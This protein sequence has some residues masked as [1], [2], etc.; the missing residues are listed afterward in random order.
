M[1]SPKCQKC[2]GTAW[3]DDGRCVACHTFPT[4]GYEIGR[5]IEE[6][7]A[8]PDRDQVGEPFLLTDEQWTFLLHF[9]RINPHAKHDAERDRWRGAFHYSRGAQLCRPQKWG[10]G[11]FS[12]AVVCAEA[13]GPVVFDGWD[14]EGR[15][16]GR[17]NATPVIQLTALS[18]DQTDNVW[19]ALLPMIALG[20][21]ESDIPETGLMRVWLP[22]GGYIEPVTSA[23]KSRLGQRVTFI[24]QDQTESWTR[25][26]GGRALADT[27][28]RNLAG[29]G[30][31]WLSTPNAWDPAEESVAQYTAEV[32]AAAGDVYNDD[33]EPAP[34]LSVRNKAERRRA[35]RSVYRDS[36]WVDLDRIDSEIVALLPRDPAQAERWFLNRKQSTESAAFNAD[37]LSD[38][39]DESR[40]VAD[41]AVI[42][43]GIDGARFVDA[44]AVVA[45][46]AKT[47]YQWPIGIWERPESAPDDYEHPLVEVDGAVR[48]AFE[49]YSVW[50][51]YVDP[52]YIEGL[53]E[54]WQGAYGEKVV[55]EW[56][57]NRPRQIAFAVRAYTDAMAAGD[58]SLADDADFLRHLRQARRQKLNVYDD[59]HRQMHTLSKDRPDSPRKIDA[60]M[61]AV[62]SWE[63]RGDCVAAGATERTEYRTAG[64]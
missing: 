34:G 3:D 49:T 21:F 19:M 10:K 48:E 7:C 46:E 61:A 28:R 43:L 56:R 38:G 40:T 2:G 42:T 59:Q 55:L 25:H 26:N 54:K 41:G 6:R 30:G 4:L 58:V 31:R 33:V 14:A 17:T 8:I 60:A 32:E 20:N 52:Q 24:V 50:R 39:V 22:G 29:M 35:L 47:G 63:A 23:A 36:Y 27:Q 18:E 57:T 37:V 51:A 53:V 44:L 13:A 9:Y 62:L 11:P 45:T 1:A 12:G 64:F 16:V 5:W 15:P